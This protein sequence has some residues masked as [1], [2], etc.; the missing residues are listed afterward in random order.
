MLKCSE[1]HTEVRQSVDH[2]LCVE[3][4][5]LR[6]PECHRSGVLCWVPPQPAGLA[7]KINA[8]FDYYCQ[9]Y[10]TDTGVVVNDPV[11]WDFPCPKCTGPS[12]MTGFS[13][14]S[15]HHE[16]LECGFKFDVK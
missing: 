3:I 2:L 6:C 1:C 11:G 12:K 8:T 13:C 7:R 16:C 9:V 15:E 4:I 14:Y 5:H 10:R